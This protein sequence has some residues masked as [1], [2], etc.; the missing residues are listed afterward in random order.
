M[1]ENNYIDHYDGPDDAPPPPC[2]PTA[3]RLQPT[4]VRKIWYLLID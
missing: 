3:N 2:P 4:S 1:R